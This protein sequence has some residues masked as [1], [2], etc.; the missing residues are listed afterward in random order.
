MKSIE[1]CSIMANNVSLLIVCTGNTCRSPMAEV[2]L[3]E[4]LKSDAQFNDYIVH[5]AGTFAANN[6]PASEYAQKV[7]KQKQLDLSNH[8]SKPITKDMID[9]A[10]LILTMTESHLAQL[11]EAFPISKHKVYPFRY[12]MEGPPEDVSDPFGGSYSDYERCSQSIEAAIPSIIKHL[13]ESL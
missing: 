5:S 9:R 12:F 11:V 7:I 6:H 10:K 1:N 8:S 2:L 13:K 4:A 3:R